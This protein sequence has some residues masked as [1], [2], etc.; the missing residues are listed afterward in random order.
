MGKTKSKKPA[1]YEPATFYEM[2]SKCFL[3]SSR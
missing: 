1:D 3:A 2:V